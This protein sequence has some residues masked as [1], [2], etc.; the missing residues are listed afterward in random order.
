[1]SAG[2]MAEISASSATTGVPDSGAA[3]P[4]AATSSRSPIPDRAAATPAGMMPSSS[5]TVAN[6]ISTSIIACTQ[7]RS[8]VTAA[9]AGV[10]SIG[11]NSSSD[12]KE[13][14]RL[15]IDVALDRSAADVDRGHQ[16]AQQ[17][18]G[19]DRDPHRSAGQHREPVPA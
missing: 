11:S 14:I 2:T 15:E 5:S 12:G 17:A 1:M 13:L 3:A 9:M 6:A 8:L 4:M 18:A 7:A 16:P 19:E 10:V